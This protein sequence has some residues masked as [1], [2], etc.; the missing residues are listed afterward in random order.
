MS[1]WEGAGYYVKLGRDL[2]LCQTE[3]GPD[4]MSDWEGT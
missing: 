1:D 4:T 2:I 3:K